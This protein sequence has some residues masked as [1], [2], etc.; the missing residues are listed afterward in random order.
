MG[1]TLKVEMAVEHFMEQRRQV[2]RWPI[3]VPRETIM[4]LVAQEQLA[5]VLPVTPV[6]Q[7]Q[8]EQLKSRNTSNQ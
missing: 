1:L 4:A 7:E 3:P 2:R 5:Q 6:A 8:M